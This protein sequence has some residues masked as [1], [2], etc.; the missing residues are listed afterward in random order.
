MLLL[1]MIL[2]HVLQSI[3][4]FGVLSENLPQLRISECEGMVD[5]KYIS[6]GRNMHFGPDLESLIF[7][8]VNNLKELASVISLIGQFKMKSFNEV[9][10]EVR[11]NHLH[12]MKLIELFRLRCK[13]FNGIWRYTYQSLT[14]LFHIVDNNI[15][16]IELLEIFWRKNFCWQI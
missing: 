2:E 10:R 13:L 7:L 16:A 5:Q 9:G 14:L 12:P 4:Y 11:S 3:N 15:F 8:I 1:R 6:L